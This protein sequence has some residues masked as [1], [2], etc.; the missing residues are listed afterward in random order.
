MKTLNGSSYHSTSLQASLLAVAIMAA[1][2]L[3]ALEVRASTLNGCES[4]PGAMRQKGENWPSIGTAV[5]EA[6]RQPQRGCLAPQGQAWVIAPNGRF[7]PVRALLPEGTSSTVHYEVRM[8][9]TSQAALPDTTIAPLAV[10]GD[11]FLADGTGDG[12]DLPSVDDGSEGVAAGRNAR[13]SATGAL[14]LGRDAV[15][16]GT[17]SVVLGSGAYVNAAGGLGGDFDGAIAI[18]KEALVSGAGFGGVAVGMSSAAEGDY[19]TAIGADA[20][21]RAS[22]ALA[23][24]QAAQVG[25]ESS[26]AFGADSVVQSATRAVALGAQSEA[27]EDDTVSVGNAS[28]KRRITN[29]ADAEKET[30]A[31]TLKQVR[32][33]IAEVAAGDTPYVK[34]DGLN[35][36]T[37]DAA[38]VAGT[39]SVAIGAGA[40][41]PAQGAVALGA[42]SIADV[43]GSVSFGSAN[44]ERR[45]MHV[46]TAVDDTDAINKKQLEDALA[47]VGGGAGSPYLAADGVAGEEAEVGAGSKSVALGDRK[48][49]V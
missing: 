24:G 1:I 42:G 29:L 18:G 45:L 49:V 26:V 23:F 8:Q 13:V 40:N 10:S 36:G 37:D 25:G 31:T 30:D 7:L 4:R 41:A 6:L 19:A 47:N 44:N 14:A 46:A 28:L 34:T 2:A 43:D 20:K 38:V 32:G 3:P 16:E 21:A 27:D 35:D 15:A 17:N 48:S 12:S 9:G 33:L 5:Y 22:K 39:R 11:Y